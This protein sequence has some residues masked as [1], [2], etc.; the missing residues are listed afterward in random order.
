MRELREL[1]ADAWYE[2]Q[3]S[4]ND[5]EPL[6]L[7]KRNID[8]FKQVLYEAREIYGFMLRGLK[9]DG[10]WVS[11]YIKPDDG[12]QLPEIMQLVKQTFSVRFNVRAGRTGHR[13][14]DRYESEI[15]ACPPEWAEAYVFL[16]VVR[17]AWRDGGETGCGEWVRKRRER[18]RL[19]GQ[20]GAGREG[21]PLDGAGGG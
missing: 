10:A 21:Q 13:W 14:G 11:F 9:F 15:V 2:V 17:G 20:S 19:G 16:P 7:S 3:T 6:F 12:L 1:A 5:R 8:L 18:R 4:V